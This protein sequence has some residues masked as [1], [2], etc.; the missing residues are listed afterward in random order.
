MATISTITWNPG[1]KVDRH[2]ITVHGLSFF[3]HSRP[4]LPPHDEYAIVQPG[5][6]LGP[7]LYSAWLS[8]CRRMARFDPIRK[9]W[10]FENRTITRLC[11][12]EGPEVAPAPTPSLTPEQRKLL[13]EQ[14]KNE[15]NRLDAALM[16]LTKHENVPEELWSS[17]QYPAHLPARDPYPTALQRIIVSKFWKQMFVGIVASVGTGKSRMTIDIC[18]ARALSDDEA[19]QNSCRIILVIAPLTLHENWCREFEKWGSQSTT[20]K[21]HKYVPGVEF[22]KAVER[23]AARLF[24]D[25]RGPRPG[26]LVIIT[27]PQRWA[28]PT[29]VQD[30]EDHGLCPTLI[31]IDEVQKHFRNPKNKAFKNVLR[32]RHEHAHS[33][34]ELTG[35]PTSKMHDWWGLEEILGGG[36]K[37]VHFR[38]GTHPQYVELFSEETVGVAT[39]GGRGWNLDRAIR[40]FH[41]D[42]IE[43]QFV[44]MALKEYYMRDALPNQD[45]VEMGDYADVRHDFAGLCEKFP[46]FVREAVELQK[47]IHR[48]DEDDKWK[49]SL[50]N[51]LMLISRMQQIAARSRE[52]RETVSAFINDMLDD[53]EPAVFWTLNYEEQEALVEFLKAFGTV[54]VINGQVSANERQ[55]AVDGFTDGHIRFLVSQVE[56]GGVGLNLVKACKAFFHSIPMSYLAVSQAI[57]RLHRIGQTKDV[58]SYFNMSHPINTFARYIYDHRTTVNERIPKSIAGLLENSSCT[59]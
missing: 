2:C 3:V 38:Q 37:V 32:M 41:K 24:E 42:R 48:D 9:G 40:E 6:F 11:S 45:Q 7:N 59:R 39:I 55:K 15:S 46:D 25:R 12:G 34:I 4:F 20:W 43:K 1:P 28:R 16:E 22:W 56:A 47:E 53:D 17:F 54:A 57:G 44:F 19:L 18:N 5:G 23:D 14:R 35:T 58:T 13:R 51:P 30:F 10:V 52:S 36:N 31:V 26:G 33:V 29:I 50:D 49:E 21:T 27:T 8:T